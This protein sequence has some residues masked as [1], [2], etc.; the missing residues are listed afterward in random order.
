MELAIWE[1]KSSEHRQL[2]PKKQEQNN[3]RKAVQAEYTKNLMKG[4]KE[5]KQKGEMRKESGD[6]FRRD[7]LGQL[8][9]RD[10]RVGIKLSCSSVI[11]S[12]FRPTAAPKTV[13]VLDATQPRF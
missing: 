10:T 11:V 12:S 4:R 2:E 8:E 1:L 9:P 7:M 3:S 6:G 13:A 5:E